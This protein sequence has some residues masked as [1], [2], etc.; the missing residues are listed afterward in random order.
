VALARGG[1]YRDTANDSQVPYLKMMLGFLG[2]TDV[3]FIYA[4]GLAMGAEAVTKGFAQA[5]ADL[6]D[7]L[8]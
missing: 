8:A 4:E 5:E 2:L 7:A 3:S 6:N 1:L